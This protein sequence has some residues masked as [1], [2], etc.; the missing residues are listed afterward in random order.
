MKTLKLYSD[1]VSAGLIQPK[2]KKYTK[3]DVYAVQVESL[4]RSPIG[5]T[6]STHEACW[7][8]ICSAVFHG[9]EFAPSI[10]KLRAR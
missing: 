10:N 5:R 1:V 9:V 3:R 6:L 2:K 4:F 7:C 8:V